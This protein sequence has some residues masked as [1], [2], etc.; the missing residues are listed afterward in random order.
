KAG[1]KAPSLRI[2]SIDMGGGT[3][4]L[5]ITTYALNDPVAPLSLITP[6]QDFRDGFNVAGDDIMR[7]IILNQFIAKIARAAAEAG[8]PDAES[9]VGDL[10]KDTPQMGAAPG[11][12]AG[13]ILRGQFVAQT[14]VPVALHILKRYEEADLSGDDLEF[15]VR[16]G[17]VPGLAGREADGRLA[18][19]LGYMEKPLRAAGW[20]DFSLLDLTLA[21][22]LR[23][24]DRDADSIVEKMMADMGEVVKLYDCDVLILTGRPSR[25]PAMMRAPY[26]RLF[27]PVDRV[28]HMH[29]YRVGA[30]YPFV[31]HGRIED[32]KTTVVVGAIICAL[33]EGSLEGIAIDT[34]NFVPQPTTRYL[35]ELD[36]HG[37]LE[38]E[39]VWFADI[40]VNS[41]KEF[42]E[43][44]GI[45]FKG[46]TAVGFRQ[47][48]CPRWTTTR[49]YSLEFK[50]A[51][52][53]EEA[54]G[55]LPYAVS[56]EYSL[57]EAGEPD[58][59]P[60]PPGRLRR[61]EGVLKVLSVVDKNGKGN[62]LPPGKLTARL[63]TLRRDDG[64]WLDTGALY[65]L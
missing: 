5:S 9:L 20:A 39:L 2:A 29:Q 51:E 15:S 59:A 16:V 44:C 61:A 25:W 38:R 36:A 48:S 18:E 17:D 7:Q 64:Y 47:L 23:E 56:I 10:F 30:G 41:D 22:D 1:A 12:N 54:K 60:R 63:Q 43:T 8:V 35:G 21:V 3:T 52:A 14:A 11:G 32:P 62:A 53:Q 55:R 65:N 31:A 50:T 37:R 28:V 26:A 24:V 42:K 57:K 46:P 6:R 58:E 33:A 4:D 45:T 34:A 49:L 13:K 19:V 40:D 27:L